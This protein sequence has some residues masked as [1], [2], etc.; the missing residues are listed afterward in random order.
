MQLE[1]D[2]GENEKVKKFGHL[3]ELVGIIA[4]AAIVTYMF[5][6]AL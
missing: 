2:T 1:Q 4:A 5:M 6:L 3:P